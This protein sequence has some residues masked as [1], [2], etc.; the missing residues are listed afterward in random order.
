MEDLTRYNPDGSDLRRMQMRMLE[1]LTFIDDI[2]S[3]N[4]IEYWLGAGTLLGAVRHGGFI[5]WDDD[6]DIELQKDDYL[7]LIKILTKESHPDFVI[8]T[9]ETDCNYVLPFAKLRDKRSLITEHKNCDRNYKFRGIFIDIFF[10]EK[11]N[12]FLVRTAVN[13]QK[14]PFALTLLKNDPFGL[15]VSL[16]N[17]SYFNIHKIFLPLLRILVKISKIEN[18]V[19]PLGTGFHATRNLPDILPLSKIN[20]EGY[21]FNAPRQPDSYLREIYGA[22]MKLPDEDKRRVHSQKV[23]FF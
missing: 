11:G 13:I 19:L 12:N 2:C 8:Q 6:L 21:Y 22:Y 5:P 18:F 9:H 15:L 17:F 1:M 3:K 14:I 4:N 23:Y 20:F 7:K 16:R 10:L